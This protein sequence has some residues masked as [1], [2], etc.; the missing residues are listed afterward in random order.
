MVFIDGTVVNVA[1]P[2]MQRALDA[3][4]GD[5]QCIVEAYELMLAALLL[6][7]GAPRRPLLAAVAFV[8]GVAC[9]SYRIRSLRVFPGSKPGAQRLQPVGHCWWLRVPA[10]ECS[11]VLRFATT[12]WAIVSG[13]QPPSRSKSGGPGWGRLSDRSRPPAPRVLINAPLAVAVLVLTF[14]CLAFRVYRQRINRSLGLIFARCKW[15]AS[16]TLMKRNCRLEQPDDMGLR[17]RWV[18]A[19]AAHIVMNGAIPHHLPLRRFSF[20]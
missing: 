1:L 4:L 10:T 12:R 9:S 20:G 19:P 6:V 7:G 2:A 8:V 18:C 5:A 13:Q 14:S 11:R 16:F 15:V 17:W 3:T